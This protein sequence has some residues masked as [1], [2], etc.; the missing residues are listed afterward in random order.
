MTAAA[1]ID[2]G[3]RPRDFHHRWPTL[4]PPLR[5]HADVVAAVASLVDACPDPVVLLGVTPEL[6]AIERA[7]IAVDWSR[8]M[9]TLAWPG[10]T[11]VRR[12]VLGDWKALPVGDRSVGAVIGDGALTMLNWPQ[13]A[14]VVAAEIQR[15]LRPGGRAVLRCFAT[16]EEPESIDFIGQLS[17]QGRMSFHEWRLRF[18]MAA[19]HAD[20]HVSITSARLYELYEADWPNRRDYIDACGWPGEALAEIDAY[21]DSAYVHS[22]PKRSEITGLL[23]P[24]WSGSVRFVETSGYPGAEHCPLLVLDRT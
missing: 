12:A 19:A 1:D 6:A 14:A 3:A 20:G 13:E 11:A 22:Y 17:A 9:I 5:P 2:D 23:A 18:N 8:D 16:P 24:I 21:R 15:V 10:D 7:M 4:K